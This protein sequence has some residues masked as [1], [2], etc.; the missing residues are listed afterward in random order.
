MTAFE[1]RH[2]DV[3]GLFAEMDRLCSKVRIHQWFGKMRGDFFKFGHH[4]DVVLRDS[5][6]RQDEGVEGV[7]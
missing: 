4:V 5:G 7:K 3:V 2:A 1:N 6:L